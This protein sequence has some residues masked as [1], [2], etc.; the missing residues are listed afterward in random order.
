[1]AISKEQIKTLAVECG[2]ELAGVAAAG[3]LADYAR[4]TQWRQAGMAAGLSYLTDHRGD[5]R[6]DPESLLPGVQSIV[7]VG[8]IYNT[9]VDSAR[10]DDPS[11]GT[12]SRY[13]HGV[14][15][16][17]V[18]RTGLK[19]LTAKIAELQSEPFES[20]ICVDT[21]PL[22]ERS[23]ARAAGL[24][25]IGRNTCLINQGAGSWLF[26][27]ELLLTIPLAP[28]MPAPDR[29]GTCRRCIDA[30]PTAALIPAGEGGSYLDARLCIS[31]LTIEHRGETPAAMTEAL[32]SHLFGCDIC[33]EVCPW[34]RRAPSTG[35]DG[36]RDQIPTTSLVDLAAY[37]ESDFALTFRRSP[38]WRT[39][40]SGFLRN[41]A[42]AMGN[43]GQDEMQEPLE[44][45][46]ASGDPLIASAA[47][48][49]LEKLA[50]SKPAFAES[51]KGPC[52]SLSES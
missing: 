16:H 51:E 41:V 15:Y 25:W 38:I 20:R 23:L 32:G 22:L 13:A 49:A 28:D 36:F 3:P 33:Q 52:A 19:S 7:C 4:F 27:G 1:M 42:T 31:Y 14:D 26:L 24:G 18:L 50:V 30:C 37:T 9:P 34:N 47:Q 8:K 48:H 45:L 2:F 46:A 21:A 43:S 17:E 40:Y 12:I 10:R 39:K 5:M 29:C 35:D 44:R 6:S 11:Q